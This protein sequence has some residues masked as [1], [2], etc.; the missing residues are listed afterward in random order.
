MLNN[1]LI[2]SVDGSFILFMLSY[3]TSI[4]TMRELKKKKTFLFE[5][6]GLYYRLATLQGALDFALYSSRV[7]SHWF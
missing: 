5:L 7:V 1:C 3:P 2:K 4:V 6:R